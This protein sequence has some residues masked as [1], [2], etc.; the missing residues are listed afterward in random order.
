MNEREPY[1]EEDD[2]PTLIQSMRYNYGS[3]V[4]EVDFFDGL[5][6][7]FCAEDV[8]PSIGLMQKSP[9][10]M[11]ALEAENNINKLALRF[12]KAWHEP[13]EKVM[14]DIENKPYDEEDYYADPDD[15]GPE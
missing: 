1:D 11:Q 4:F 14:S 7:E 5:H 13:K 2:I 15:W 9:T 10:R 12:W 6:L 8:S 3:M